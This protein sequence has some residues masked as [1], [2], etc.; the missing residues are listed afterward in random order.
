MENVGALVFVVLL[1]VGVVAILVWLARSGDQSRAALEKER[2]EE[3]TGGESGEGEVAGEPEAAE[4]EADDGGSPIPL[5]EA[6]VAGLEVPDLDAL[7]AAADLRTWPREPRAW[8]LGS[9]DSPLPLLQRAMEQLELPLP[10]APVAADHLFIPAAKVEAAAQAFGQAIARAGE[11]VAML[12]RLEREGRKASDPDPADAATIEQALK[13]GV[14]LA[15]LSPASDAARLIHLLHARATAADRPAGESL[16]VRVRFAGSRE[17][18]RRLQGAPE[19]EAGT[20]RTWLLE[21]Q[22]LR[23]RISEAEETPEQAARAMAAFRAASLSAFFPSAR[24][25]TYLLVAALQ[26]AGLLFPLRR[27]LDPTEMVFVIPGDEV[28]GALHALEAA[29]A[30]SRDPL[31]KKDAKEAFLTALAEL[32]QEDPHEG[33]RTSD[34]AALREALDGGR[35]PERPT[36]AIEAAAAV[37]TLIAVAREADRHKD[38]LLLLHR[39]CDLSA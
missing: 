5:R 34:P 37:R 7:P 23:S 19:P 12:E 27:S 20:P 39:R 15:R 28:N 24:Q 21:L 35:L 16:L 36:P 30:D 25:V 33:G 26:K 22:V 6:L 11:T 3:P 17:C 38:D 9:L 18:L 2:V 31:L 29:A 13:G 32:E 10:V 14:E 1:L 4:A 8:P